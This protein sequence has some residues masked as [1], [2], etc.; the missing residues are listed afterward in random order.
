MFRKQLILCFIMSMLMTLT[1]SPYASAAAI[2]FTDSLQA[3]FNATADKAG[4][5]T[6]TKL[7]KQYN[8]F[9][10][11]QKQ[12]MDWDDRISALHYSNEAK[13]S[14]MRKRI[15]E[16]DKDKIRRLEEQLQTAKTK[17]QPL[18]DSYTRLNK[19]ITA[20]KKL[21]DKTL[22][23]ML[24]SQADAMKII[25]TLARQDIR[26]KQAALTAAKKDKS[27]KAANIRSIL[28]DI[29]PYKSKI[30]SDKSA[31]STL[32]KL[33]STEWKNFKAAI[34]ANDSART[35]DIL[36][37]LLT[38]SSQILTKKKSIFNH[39]HKIETI[40]ARAQAQLR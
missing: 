3:Q 21:K 10:S 31:I 30:K 39:E 34:K 29:D 18:F 33:L 20:A 26:N 11:E 15:S 22:S 19:Q 32:K 24:Q 1:L 4:S 2:E 23:K 9:K 36:K 17:S 12:A 6:R 5:T 27:A 35:S 25:V 7:I 28:S 13:I 37:R 8:D 14:E 38:L 40:I 16:I